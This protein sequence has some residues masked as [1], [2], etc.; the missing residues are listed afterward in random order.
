MTAMVDKSLKKL[1]RPKRKD[2]SIRSNA[3]KFPASRRE[4]SSRERPVSL[5]PLSLEEAIRGLAATKPNPNQDVPTVE[6]EHD[7]K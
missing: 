7:A 3:A 5:A 6:G 1:V 2:A 4:N